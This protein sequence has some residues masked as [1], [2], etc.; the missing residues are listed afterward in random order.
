MYYMR[1]KSAKALTHLVAHQRLLEQLPTNAIA[2]RSMLFLVQEAQQQALEPMREP[3]GQI[4]TGRPSC[5]IGREENPRLRCW[6]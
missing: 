1:A 5:E 2:Q 6:G 3:L 4:R